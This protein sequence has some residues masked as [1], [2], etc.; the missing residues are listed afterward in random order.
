M[1]NPTSGTSPSGVGSADKQTNVTVFDREAS[2]LASEVFVHELVEYRARL[3]PE[4][5][6]LVVGVLKVNY[7]ELNARAH[8]LAAHLQTLGVGPDTVVALCMRRSIAMVVG[9]LAI[10]KAGGAY[11]P[12]DP[13]YP[14]ARQTA[15]LADA[16]VAIAV[17]TERDGD[18]V[19]SA[20][21]QVVY[22]DNEG[23]GN[24]PKAAEASP[25]RL[26]PSNLAYVI[27]TSGSTG[28]PKG[29]EIDHS[30]LSNLTRWHLDTFQVNSGDRASQ[31][32][33]VAFDASVWELWP[34][35]AVGA[36]VHI[37]EEDLLKHTEGL[38]DWIVE[39]RI[40]MSFVPTPIAERVLTLAWPKA[41]S[42]RYLLTGADTLHCYPP[43]GLPFT[44]VN[45]YGPTECTVVATSTI[46]PVVE[47]PTVLP[48]IG[49][50]ISNVEVFILND[51]MEEMPDGEV[52]ELYI[53]GAGVGRGYRGHPDLTA[54]FFFRHTFKGEFGVRL[55]KTGDLARRLADGQISFL[56]RADD[57]AKI[58][59][60]RVELGGVVAVLNSHPLVV[61]SAVVPREF[62]VGDKRLVA[63]VVSR[64]PGELTSNSLRDYLSIRLPAHMV[65]VSFVRIDSVPINSSG[66]VDQAAL[67]APD[68]ANS[69][70]DDKYVAPRTPLEKRLAGI[71]AP[72]LCVT[73]IGAEDNFFVLGGH[74][75][76]RTQV[77]ARVRDAF[78]VELSLRSL[79]D[80]PTIAALALEVEALLV[81]RVDAMSDEEVERF[82]QAASDQTSEAA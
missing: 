14:A 56:G 8:R 17:T 19:S 13:S 25:A 42:L 44:L 77:I 76:L 49:R 15:I 20:C 46:V 31:L 65:P 51:K 33:G 16:Q 40:T 68:D 22:L 80:A 67:P 26:K 50:P 61:E 1:P 72:L 64:V 55:Y 52:G 18:Q 11:L 30:N 74:S 41:T 21:R 6:A 53:A 78:G 4:A 39:Q 82:L 79:F 60:F 37:S 35:L 36:S 47:R 34:Y 28:Q 24:G 7:G 2:R 73:Q 5:V 75:L 59:G 9:A 3:E 38:R 71:L 62:G 70:H 54:Q 29:V 23:H 58:R 10:L 27:Y 81:E 48:P 66:K 69:I 12:I 57:Q 43:S 32:C 63:Y 45:N